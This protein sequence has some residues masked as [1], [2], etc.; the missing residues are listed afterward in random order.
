MSSLVKSVK[1]YS[2]QDYF[3]TEN[4]ELP[5]V[6]ITLINKLAAEVGAPNYQKTPIFKQKRNRKYDKRDEISNKDWETLRNFKTT[7]LKKN[8]EGTLNAEIDTIRSLLNKIT[9]KNYDTLKVE[10]SDNIEKHIDNE[11]N[12]NEIC[13]S[14]FEIGS[15]NSF[16]SEMYAKLCKELV[17]KFDIMKDICKTNFTNFLDLFKNITN[18]NSE[19]DYD[20][21]CETNKINQKRRSMSSFFIHLMNFGIINV[22]NM[23]NLIYT[24][25]ENIEENKDDKTKLFCND[26]IIENLSILI[27]KG[28]ENLIHNEDSWASVITHIET[29]AKTK[30]W[31]LT[32]KT[33][34]K[35]YDI[36]DEIEESNSD[37][38]DDCNSDSSS[39]ED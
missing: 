18:Y 32:K 4:I 29:Y 39:N 15:M 30:Y 24:L 36:L 34:F 33:T 31:G 27:T 25:I 13:K 35:C 6:I 17:E 5:D 3:K 19:E 7:E 2:P 11:D 8:E 21:F 1:I 10:I 14:I 16:W 26:E 28:K 37:D 23:Y 38:D 9:G 22:D 12:L 20:K